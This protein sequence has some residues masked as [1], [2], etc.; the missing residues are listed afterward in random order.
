MVNGAVFRN[1]FILPRAWAPSLP[2]L[3]WSRWLFSFLRYFSLFLL[4]CRINL[5]L[6]DCTLRA[7]T[8]KIAQAQQIVTK[9]SVWKMPLVKKTGAL[10]FI[11][12][13]SHT[14]NF[15]GFFIAIIF[16]C[17]LLLLLTRVI[18]PQ[19]HQACNYHGFRHLV[20]ISH[21][22]LRTLPVAMLFGPA[23]FT[24]K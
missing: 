7:Y 2:A 20:C 9:R 23:S 6:G 15:L 14:G 22:F 18:V 8:C 4:H 3:T 5:T 21:F 17:W 16:L 1:P 13:Y 11:T 19:E 12:L 24:F 10:T